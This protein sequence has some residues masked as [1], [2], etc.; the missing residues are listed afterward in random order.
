AQLDNMGLT[1]WTGARGVVKK[2]IGVAKNYLNE[3]EIT[4]LNRLTNMILDYFEDQTDRERVVTM[5]GLEEALVA[6]MKFNKRSVLDGLGSVSRKDA[7]E[8]AQTQFAAYQER[9]RLA[10]QAAGETALVELVK[11]GKQLPAESKAR[12]N[13]KQSPKKSV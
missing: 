6:F 5:A 1:A 11:I 4:D 10:R 9:G 8:H 3:T 2:D 7:D 12:P 13:R